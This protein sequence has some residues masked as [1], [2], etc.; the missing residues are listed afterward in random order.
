[1]VLVGCGD[2]VS[3]IQVFGG[4][5]IV[6][7]GH[8]DEQLAVSLHD[9]KWTILRQSRAWV[10]PAVDGPVV[11]GV[12]GMH[13]QWHPFLRSGSPDGTAA[14]LSSSSGHDP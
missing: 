7:R 6:G 9:A 4:L 5:P 10:L 1:M 2:L 14:T 3:R 8:S 11:A 12:H 13:W